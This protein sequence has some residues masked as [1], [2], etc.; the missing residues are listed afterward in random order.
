MGANL[1]VDPYA[2]DLVEAAVWVGEGVGVKEIVLVN[3]SHTPAAA[4]S[5]WH[6]GTVWN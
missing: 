4:A 3:A 1:V 6:L 2:I 5:W